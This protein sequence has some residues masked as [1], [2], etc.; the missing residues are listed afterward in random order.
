MKIGLDVAQT[1]TPRA[2]CAWYADSLARALVQ[3]AP[4]DHFFLYHQ[5]GTL[6]NPDTSAGTQIVAP[7]A[8]PTFTDVTPEEANRIWGSPHELLI[9][10]GAPDLV[11]AM[12]FRAPQVP[13]AK[14]VFTVYDVSFWA[15]PQFTTEENR[16]VCQRG[17]LEALANADG[18]IFISQSSHDEFERFLPGWLEE[19]RRPWI[20]TPLAPR[21]H[22]R[23][24]PPE[25]ASERYWLAVGSIEPRKNYDALLDAFEIYWQASKRPRRLRIA[26]GRGWKSEGIHARMQ[27]LATR[28]MIEYLGYVPDDQLLSLYAGAE[29]LIF[30]TWYEGFGLP[31][32]EA[33][34]QGCPVLSSG[35][36]SLPEVGGKAVTYINPSDP[37]GIAQ[38]MLALEADPDRRRRQSAACLAQAA[39]FTWE[40]TAHL[41]LNFYRRI[42][43]AQR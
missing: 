22:Q 33:M 34:A 25:A 3:I 17:V 16:I 6:I 41:T 2:G 11:H 42:L 5:F 32:I 7:N 24:A 39:T 37:L 15:V 31:V 43:L 20:V 9:K 1:C 14:I 8:T 30:P 21:T 28:G 35:G 29:A 18:F 13:G 23:V 40:R 4:Q 36:T 26:G 19:H 12:S 10:T 38:A 27:V